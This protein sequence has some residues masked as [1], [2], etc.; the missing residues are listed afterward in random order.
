MQKAMLMLNPVMYFGASLD[1]K[2]YTAM[3]PPM[4]PNPTCHAVPT[5]RRWCPPRSFHLV[6]WGAIMAGD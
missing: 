5:A 6:S 3:M 2:E 4:F 1:K